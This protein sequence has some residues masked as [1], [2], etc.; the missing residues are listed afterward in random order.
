[1]KEDV[2]VHKDGKWAKQI[3]SLQEKDGKWGCFHSLSQ[4]YDAPMTTE[5]ALRRLERLGYTNEDECVQRAVRYMDDCLTGKKAIPDRREKVHDWDVFTELIL[6]AW[7]RRFTNDNINA[8]K[9]ADKWAEVISRAFEGG[10]YDREEYVRAYHEVLKPKGGRLVDFANFYPV[11]ILSGQLDEKTERAF[12]DCL[13][14]REDG[15]YYIYSEKI[16]VLPECFES[17]KASWYL[18]AVE[19]LAKYKCARDKLGFVAE[20]LDDNRNENGKWDMG[21]AVNDKVYFPLSDDWRK[22][23]TREADC[24]ERVTKLLF[25]L[26]E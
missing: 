23:E 3:I 22:R 25:E 5:Q 18:G 13:I 2:F 15:I 1:M 17:K 21:K 26:A 8:N 14:N 11:S 19:L 12:V 9:I 24:T 4:F 6:A 10:V 20:W 16:A 7:I